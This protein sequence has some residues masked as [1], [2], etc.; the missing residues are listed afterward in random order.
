M[1]SLVWL[2]LYSQLTG[3]NLQVQCTDNRG[4]FILN[5]RQDYTL[6]TCVPIFLLQMTRDNLIMV[7]IRIPPENSQMVNLISVQIHHIHTIKI[8]CAM[9]LQILS[10]LHTTI[11][12]CNG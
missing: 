10:T 8:N 5:F 7:M 3:R 1:S 6:A 2:R 12:F 4:Y 11:L 9:H